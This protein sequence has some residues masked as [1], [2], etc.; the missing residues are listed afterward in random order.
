MRDRTKT[1][2]LA[3]VT[4]TWRTKVAQRWLRGPT[5]KAVLAYIVDGGCSVL[6][7]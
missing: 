5:T 4:A 3:T 1:Q 6:T 7:S 2:V